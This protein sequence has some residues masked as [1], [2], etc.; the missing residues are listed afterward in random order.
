MIKHINVIETMNEQIFSNMTSSARHLKSFVKLHWRKRVKD[1]SELL[2]EWIIHILHHLLFYWCCRYS[3]LLL[4]GFGLLSFHNGIWFSLNPIKRQL[5]LLWQRCLD[6]F[7]WCFFYGLKFYLSI[8]SLLCLFF[9]SCLLSQLF[10]FLTSCLFHLLIISKS[11]KVMALLWR[12]SF[13][14]RMILSFRC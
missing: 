7:G 3:W 14:R 2:N 11:V 9:L 12:I 5:W 10:Y 13:G 6:R 4:F 1:L 8:S